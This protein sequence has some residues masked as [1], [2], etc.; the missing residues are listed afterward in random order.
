MVSFI[1]A[2][3]GGLLTAFLPCTLP[4]VVG[5][6][7]VLT[8]SG[9]KTFKQSLPPFFLFALGFSATYALIGYFIQIG[10]QAALSFTIID[11][12]APYIAALLFFIFGL[13]MFNLIPIPTFSKKSAIGLP[14]EAG[15]A[16]I[17]AGALFA[18][19][20]SPCVGPILGG[21]LTLTASSASALEGAFALF[22]FSLGVLTPF[23]LI[24]FAKKP[25][26][27]LVTS[28]PYII[29]IF[30]WSMGALFILFAFG[31]IFGFPGWVSSYS[32]PFLENAQYSIVE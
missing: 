10:T 30:Q 23:I 20:W 8:A 31:F 17:V 6:V 21:I 12:L 32:I 26:L 3:L 29:K 15:V 14:K 11:S 24:F 5:Y 2:Y 4:I 19:V 25:I 28:K 22:I 16:T 9:V 18:L 27:M 1:I 13:M 7:G